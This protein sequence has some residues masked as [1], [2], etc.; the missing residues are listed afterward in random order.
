MKI[1]FL[2]LL[3][4]LSL[5]SE[6]LNASFKIDNNAFISLHESVEGEFHAYIIFEGHEYV[7]NVVEH[8]IYCD[9][10]RN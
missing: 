1:W 5:S 4:L 9:C 8:Y 6:N 7:A 2:S 3:S 10:L